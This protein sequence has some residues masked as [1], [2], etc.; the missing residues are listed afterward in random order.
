VNADPAAAGDYVLARDRALAEVSLITAAAR[1]AAG[2]GGEQRA[3]ALVGQLVAGLP[4]GELAGLLTAA[5]L[6]LAALAQD[7]SR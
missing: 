4:H 6:R 3:A 7:G 1:E 5:V 2:S